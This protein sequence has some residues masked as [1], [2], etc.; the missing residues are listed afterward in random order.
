MNEASSYEANISDEAVQQGKV[1]REGGEWPEPLP[2]ITKI[3]SEPYPLDA[4][5]ETILAAV[6]EV[7]GFTQAPV[8]LVTGSALAA[9]S[10]A[11]QAHADVQRAEMLAGPVGLF[12]LTI[13]DSGERKSTCDSFFTKSIKAYEIEQTELAKPLI[14][15]YKAG[16]LAWEAKQGGIKDKIRQLAKTNKPTQVEESALLELEKIK[17]EAPRVP[18]LVYADFTPEELKWQLATGWPSAGVVSSEAG[19]VFGSHGMGSDS[20]MR[21]LATL[22]QLWDGADITTDRRTSESFTVRGARLTIALQVQEATLRSFFD[23]TGGLARGTGFLARFLVSS[24]ASTQGYRPFRE[25]PE[26]WPALEKFN[27]RITSIL[28]QE[29]PIDESGALTPPVYPLAPDTKQAWIAFHDAIEGEL[30]AGGELH[31]VRDVASKTADNAVRLAALFQVF[32]HETGG[33]VGMEAFAGASRITA[34]HLQEALRFYGAISLSEEQVSAAKLDSWLIEHCQANGTNCIP[35]RE[36]QR[37][38]TPVKLRN[39]IALNGALGELEDFGRVRL[40][41]EGKRKDIFINPALL[42]G[43]AE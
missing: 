41:Q 17:P 28:N 10:L 1:T 16:M 43:G 13:A 25:P 23:K 12:L 8:P 38:I 21:N 7:L 33:D 39:K 3:K 34:W 29:V 32:E 15:D 40:I 36:L 24:P 5:P 19:L 20:V 30:K 31:S 18:R 11:A 42:S 9:L 27:Q 6:N 4:L 37:N 26:A 35:R 2:L 22:N 14:A